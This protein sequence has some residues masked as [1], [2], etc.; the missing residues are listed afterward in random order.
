MDF[1]AVSNSRL[2]FAPNMS[3]HV[4]LIEIIDNHVF[5]DP[6]KNFT[7]Y[8]STH[9]IRVHLVNASTIVN[10]IDDDGECDVL[11]IYNNQLYNTYIK[12]CSNICWI[13]EH[14]LCCKRKSRY[15]EF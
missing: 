3:S 9:D 8:L 10:I 2:T 13:C 15:G 5:A 11:D 7:V 1:I 6:M 12:Y 4:I 14:Y